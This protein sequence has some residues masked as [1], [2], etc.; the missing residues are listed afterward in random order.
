MERRS[1]GSTLVGSAIAL[2]EAVAAKRRESPLQNVP[3]FV[4]AEITWKA[5]DHFINKAEEVCVQIVED[6]RKL[7]IDCIKSCCGCLSETIRATLIALDKDPVE[8]SDLEKLNK[9]LKQKKAVEFTSAW[10]KCRKQK[11]SYVIRVELSNKKAVQAEETKKISVDYIE[12]KKVYAKMTAAQV[13]ARGGNSETLTKA[14]EILNANA[15][16]T[17]LDGAFEITDGILP[18]GLMHKFR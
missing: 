8:E 5:F 12:M 17:D 18:I 6:D 11:R 1:I 16:D 4:S 2:I 14:L 15:K 13:L 10:E 7:L 3:T 9:W